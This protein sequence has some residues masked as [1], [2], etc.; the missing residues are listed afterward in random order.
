M[1]NQVTESTETMK[2]VKWFTA[3]AILMLPTT[4]NFEAAAIGPALG[5]MAE[6][7]PAAST[8]QVQLIMTMPFLGSLIFSVIAGKLCD[9]FSK[10]Y[11][12]VIGLLIYGIMGLLPGIIDMNLNLILLIRFLTG[13]GCGLVL[14]IPNMLVTENYP[15]GKRRER[16][17][18]LNSTFYNLSC[19]IISIVVG[20]ML[21]NGWR[22]AFYSFVFI[23]VVLIIALGG[24]PNKKPEAV[25]KNTGEKVKVPPYAYFM[26]LMMICTMIFTGF[27]TSSIAL[28]VTNEAMAGVAIIGLLLALP[29]GGA[30][31]TSPFYPEILKRFG[32]FTGAFGCILAAFGFL[33]AYTA[34]SVPTLIISILFMG[35]GNGVM[36]PHVLYSTSTHVTERQRDASMGIVS[37]CI[38]AAFVISPFVQAFIFKVAGFESFRLLYMVCGISLA[39]G[40]VCCAIYSFTRKNDKSKIV[41]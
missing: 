36:M 29:G 17:L 35:L 15:V 18:G 21:I 11:I 24:I 37:G 30:F 16:M 13:V 8:L 27:I 2:K 1:D 3:F 5:L 19:I 9:Y 41:A 26:A 39:V 12:T 38:H 7:F 22:W 14:P 33:F 10:K 32:R 23:F 20:I 34:N 28:F 31:I 6:H 4:W 25:Q 40:A